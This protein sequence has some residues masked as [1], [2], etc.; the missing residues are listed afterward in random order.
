MDVYTNKSK[1]YGFVEMPS[2]GESKAAVVNLNGKE[3]GSNRIRVKRS[4]TERIEAKDQN[5]PSE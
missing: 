5:H 4:T 3:V 2:P 1:G